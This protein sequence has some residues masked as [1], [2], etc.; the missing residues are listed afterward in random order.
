MSQVTLSDWEFFIQQNPNAHLLQSGS[1]G[2]LKSRFGWEPHFFIEKKC[3]AMILV[4]KYPFGFNFA[5]LPKGPVGSDWNSIWSPI[6]DFCIKEKIF[7]LRVEPDLWE[8]DLLPYKFQANGF[9]T[10]LPIQPRCTFVLDLN[11]PEEELLS[12]MKQKTRYNI[13]LAI[14][15]NIVI[16]KSS[17][18]D[19]FFEIMQVTGQRDAFGIH[20]REYYRYAYQQFSKNKTCELFIAR[21][22]KKPLAGIMVFSHGN[23]AWYLYGASK[24]DERERM[25]T[26]LLQWEAICWAKEKGCS[27]YD[28]WGIP[29]EDE[30]IL[31]QDF[32][33]RE[34]GLWGVY[35][36][37][38]GFGGKIMRSIGAWDYIYSSSRFKLFNYIMEKRKRLIL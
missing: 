23:R 27:F 8:G 12:R 19:L 17:N 11:Q 26:Y 9:V 29:D 2:L 28:L 31:E 32:M 30:K 15:K 6:H 18:T 34:D 33:R 10:S 36:F 3:G 38:R 4:K 24:N 37:K 14:K 21:Y 20:A 22:L 25:P 1:W 5:Y 35:R 13:R 16:E 7:N